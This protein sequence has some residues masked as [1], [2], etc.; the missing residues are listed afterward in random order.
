MTASAPVFRKR[1]A[2]P[3]EEQLGT[4]AHILGTAGSHSRWCLVTAEREMT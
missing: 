3:E 2:G 4:D 1:I